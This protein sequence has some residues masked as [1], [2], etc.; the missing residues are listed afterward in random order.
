MDNNKR[1]RENFWNM[2]FKDLLNAFND[3]FEREFQNTDS[4]YSEEGP[5]TFGYSMRIGPETNYQPEVRQWG[6]LNDYRQKI[7]LPQVNWPFNQNTLP[8]NASR[9][10]K[11]ERF[12]DILDEN[13]QLKII[14]EVPG[15]T[16]ENLSIEVSEEGS[17]LDLNG[18][19]MNRE[20]NERIQLPSKIEPKETKSTIKNGVLEI[21]SKKQKSS[22][23]SHKLKID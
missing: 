17:V 13:D 15:F 20:I 5:I 10:K 7:G 14:V 1:I 6:N 3:D 9:Q 11:S 12:I 2:S 22:E 16:K 8:Q 19:A 4:E 21:L 18:K 23:K